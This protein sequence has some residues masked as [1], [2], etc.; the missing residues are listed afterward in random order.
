MKEFKHHFLKTRDSEQIFYST[1][2]KPGTI[3]KDV[4]VFNYGLVCS[5]FHYKEQIKYFHEHNYPILIHDYRGHYQSS[6]MKNLENITLSNIAEDIFEIIQNVEIEKCHFIGHSM[7]VNVCFEYAKKYQDTLQSMSLIAGTLMPVH[8]IMMNTHITGP[9]NDVMMNL[10]EK[11]PKEFKLLWKYTGWNPLTR[12]L[13]HRGGFNTKQVGDDF[14]ETYLNKLG[15]L[16]PELFLQLINEMQQHDLLAFI[17]KIKTPCLLIGGNRDKVIPNFQ[18]R[19]LHEKLPHS[20]VYIVHEGS[21]VPQV[22]FPDMVNERIEYFINHLD[23][24]VTTFKSK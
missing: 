15:Q 20:E 7:G 16:G 1:N 8:N 19:L 17:H 5:N 11:Y 24:K 3:K 10:I 9:I 22:D 14:I 18:Q 21:H 13:V 12:K 23:D 6:G 4:I 2:F